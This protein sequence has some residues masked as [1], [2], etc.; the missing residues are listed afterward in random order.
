L[1]YQTKFKSFKSFNS[2]K[3]F[4]AFKPFNPAFVLPRVRRGGKHALS[5]IE[6]RWGHPRS[7]L[8][9]WDYFNDLNGYWFFAHGLTETPHSCD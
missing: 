8:N 3:S 9:D 6:G 5:C 7:D 2:F 4:K 1:D